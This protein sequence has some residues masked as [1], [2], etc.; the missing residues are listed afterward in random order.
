MKIAFFTVLFVFVAAVSLALAHPPSDITITYDPATK[1][2]QAVI[3]HPVG[4]PQTHFIDKVDVSLNGKEVLTQFISR[5][6]NNNSQAVSYVIPDAKDGDE[7]SV[8][9]YCSI[10]GKLE[11]EVKAGAR[12]EKK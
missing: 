9:A 5:Q 2:L 1:T 11:K 6:D 4:N 8:E 3:I 7:L 12:R 10:S